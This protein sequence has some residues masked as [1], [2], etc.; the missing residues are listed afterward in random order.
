MKK[1]LIMAVAAI[2]VLSSCSSDDTL[3]ELG[4]IQDHTATRFRA[5]IDDGSNN[6]SRTIVVDNDD[7]TGKKVLW[8][9]G[10]AI[11]INGVTYT[12]TNNSYMAE[13]TTS[14]TPAVA[15]F[16][17]MYKAYYP[18]SLY[19]DGVPALP[20][21]YTYEEGKFDMPMYAE[22]QDDQLSFKNLCGV[23]AITISSAD[24]SE[25]ASIEVSSDIQLNGIIGSITSEGVLTFPSATPADVERRITLNFVTPK[26]ITSS[27]TFYIPIPAGVH[28]PLTILVSDGTNAQAMVTRKSGGVTVERSKIYPINFQSNVDAYAAWDYGLE[29][30]KEDA[31]SIEIENLADVSTF[32]SI[33]YARYLNEECTIWEVYDEDTKTVKISTS[34][35]MIKKHDYVEVGFSGYKKVKSIKGLEHLD[36][37]DVTN[38]G[39]MFEGC[40]SLTR[41]DLSSFNTAKAINMSCMFH[42]CYH[43]EYL[44]LGEGFVFDNVSDKTCM[45]M[46]CGNEVEGKG[47][48]ICPMNAAL[49]TALSTDTYFDDMCF[50]NGIAKAT[51]NGEEVDVEWVQMRKWGAKFAVYNVG[52]T[53]G[54]IASYG[55]HYTWGGFIDGDVSTWNTGTEDLEGDTDT[56]YVLWGSNWRMSTIFEISNVFSGCDYE[57]TTIEGVNGYLCTGKDLYKDNKLFIPAAGLFYDQYGVI[58]VGKVGRYWGPMCRRAYRFGSKN[59]TTDSVYGAPPQWYGYSVRAVLNE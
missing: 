51:I 39:S 5:I 15:N 52:V 17:G 57:W 14:G 22:T 53:D 47:I 4:G 18:V 3:L 16:D 23:L 58:D 43:L 1:F 35:L 2:A 29:F 38:M 19:N 11:C 42:Q 28:N 10:D 48:V 46:E 40:E 56:A 6:S 30:G 26:I 37:S 45:F 7:H 54:K 34:A 8:S 59:P 36:M 33:P 20:A 31:I 25:V 44:K 32:P 50:T 27:E 55:G 21:E 41:L 24:F 13:F 9:N 49:R 12:T